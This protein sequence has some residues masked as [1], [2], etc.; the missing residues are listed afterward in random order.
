[1]RAP[2]RRYTKIWVDTQTHVEKLQE[3]FCS[4]LGLWRV[5]LH[6]EE[7]SD[8]G[9]LFVHGIAKHA[10]SKRD[11]PLR[12]TAKT[13]SC[14]RWRELAVQREALHVPIERVERVVRGDHGAA[15]RQQG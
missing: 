3:S 6:P 2:Q 8:E 10:T 14:E 11:P 13:F 4:A 1:M 5:R 15:A 12:M 7:R 9:S